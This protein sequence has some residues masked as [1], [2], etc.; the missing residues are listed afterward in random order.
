MEVVK[1]CR[2]CLVNNDSTRVL[3]RGSPDADIMV[4]LDRFRTHDDN[5]VVL[6]GAS[7]RIF[8]SILDDAGISLEDVY[9]TPLVKCQTQNID[10]G[11]LSCKYELW[12]EMKLVAPK[13]LVISGKSS[14]RK[15]LKTKRTLKSTFGEIFKIDFLENC[16][17]VTCPSI[18]VCCSS[19][20]GRQDIVDT[21]ALAKSLI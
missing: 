10:S 20:I 17:A 1:L 12:R 16:V 6:D 15:I 21:M 18:T 2:K 4:I 9:I 13:V 11:F 3:P 7:V 8:G 14:V 19:L 5:N